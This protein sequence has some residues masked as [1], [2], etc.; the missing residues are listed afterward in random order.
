MDGWKYRVCLKTCLQ[1]G[2]L[3]LSII[4][5]YWPEKSPVC[6]VYTPAGAVENHCWTANV[7]GAGE[8]RRASSKDTGFFDVLLKK[9]FHPKKS[10]FLTE[11]CSQKVLL[12]FRK[13]CVWHFGHG[14]FDV[15]FTKLF[16]VDVQSTCWMLNSVSD[17]ASL[18]GTD[19]KAVFNLFKWLIYRCHAFSFLVFW[20]GTWMFLVSSQFH[21]IYI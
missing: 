1:G 10:I 4:A 3:N 16:S 5:A 6:I 8:N 14:L 2:M 7:T 18:L 21:V 19:D 9:D 15:S 13:F 17:T 20:R 12:C 11:L